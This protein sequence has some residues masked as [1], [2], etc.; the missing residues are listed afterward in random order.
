[1]ALGAVDVLKAEGIRV[2]EEV[3]VV[4]F[5]DIDEARLAI[6]Q[7]TTVRQSFLVLGREAVKTALALVNGEAVPSEVTV[8]TQ[9]V[10]RRSCGCGANTWD[11]TEELAG[12]VSATASH[13]EI[14]QRFLDGFATLLVD[15]IS[16][17][18][19]TAVELF[20]SVFAEIDQGNTGQFA[21]QLSELIRSNSPE[22]LGSLNRLM[23]V[24][25]RTLHAWIGVDA[26]RRQRADEIGRQ[27][28]ASVG[29][30][31]EL[32]QGTQRVRLQRL[33][34]EL[35]EATKALIG[36]SG[37]D[38]VRSALDTH[39]KNL[40]IR[41]CYLSLYQDTATPHAGAKLVWAQNSKDHSVG[42]FIGQSFDTKQLVPFGSL[43][44]EHRESIVIE[45]L[46]F[47][48][49]QLGMLAMSMGPDEGVVYEA[50][51][52]QLSGAIR[53]VRLVEKLAG[54]SP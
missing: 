35:S 40:G 33:T 51:R 24:I 9:V 22:L 52:D 21:R 18:E 28:R 26:T 41:T 31:G 36:V 7:L 20:E 29:D 13:E 2:P 12:A 46:F 3:S 54:T 16:V 38:A 43:F 42:K 34:F 45:P 49:E 32:A 10:I 25:F 1:M 50:I 14:R 4:G 6:P 47:E 23:T 39:M 17:T 5:D 48:H 37:F 8:A 27:V 19:Q 15:G 44:R 11:I 53:V 30:I